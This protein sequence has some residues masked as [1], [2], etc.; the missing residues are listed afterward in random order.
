M[1]FV[2]DEVLIMLKN[3]DF[4]RGIH[5]QTQIIITMLLSR[6]VMKF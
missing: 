5:K 2:S 3:D 1:K 4:A 6:G